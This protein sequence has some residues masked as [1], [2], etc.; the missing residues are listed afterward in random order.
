VS[1]ILSSAVSSSLLAGWR[2]I[3]S[4]RWTF[5]TSVYPPGT[6]FGD[7]A[8]GTANRSDNLNTAAPSYWKFDQDSLTIYSESEMYLRVVFGLFWAWDSFCVAR[9]FWL[10]CHIFKT[11]WTLAI[12]CIFFCSASLFMC[13]WLSVFAISNAGLPPASNQLLARANCEPTTFSQRA[14]P[15]VFTASSRLYLA[16]GKYWP[17]LRQHVVW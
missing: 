7:K 13:K 6:A 15:M 10:P 2:S 16:Q 5:N 3:H 1:E 14:S 12:L 9:R 11:S 8:D 17:P 4:I